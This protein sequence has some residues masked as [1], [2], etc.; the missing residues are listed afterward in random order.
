MKNTTW[1]CSVNKLHILTCT[2]WRAHILNIIPNISVEEKCRHADRQWQI[3][4]WREKKRVLPTATGLFIGAEK[5]ASI[6]VLFPAQWL[7]LDNQAVQYW[8]QRV[9][10]TDTTW[11]NHRQFGAET[12]ECKESLKICSRCWCACRQGLW[13]CVCAG[14]CMCGGEGCCSQ[15]ISKPLEIAVTVSH[16]ALCPFV[17]TCVWCT[18]MR[19]SVCR[20]HSHGDRWEGT[21]VVY[22]SWLTHTYTHAHNASKGHRTVS[23]CLAQAPTG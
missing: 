5:A 19:A 3:Q 2:Y 10:S 8:W 20:H 17:Y 21:C 11:C 7:C 22:F 6:N 13:L 15:G 18:C 23:R 9:G 4:G 1:L 16:T 12:P 14:V